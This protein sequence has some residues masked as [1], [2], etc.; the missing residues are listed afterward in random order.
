MEEDRERAGGVTQESLER[1]DPAELPR[2]RGNDVS[3]PLEATALSLFP[4]PKES[5]YIKGFTSAVDVFSSFSSLVYLR[6]QCGLQERTLISFF[7]FI[8]SLH[9][10]FKELGPLLPLLFFRLLCLIAVLAKIE[11]KSAQN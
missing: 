10:R 11:A 5:R 7:F 3:L 9:T 2:K 4:S 8:F 1:L 6:T